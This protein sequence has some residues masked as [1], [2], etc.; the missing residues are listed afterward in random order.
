MARGRSRGCIYRAWPWRCLEAISTATIKESE[1]KQQQNYK[2]TD[3]T[4]E[5]DF[6][7]TWGGV[8]FVRRR[9]LET[10]VPMRVIL[11][12]FA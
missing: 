9:S 7:P 12:D 4:F 2:S 1:V 5:A 11:I 6:A 3:L 8:H 10:L